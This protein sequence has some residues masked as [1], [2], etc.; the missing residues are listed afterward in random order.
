MG[1]FTRKSTT[2]RAEKLPAPNLDG[3]SLDSLMHQAETSMS[4]GDTKT[5]L[6]ALDQALILDPNNPKA[7]MKRAEVKREMR[8]E[9]G[10]IK[11]VS[12]AKLMLDKIDEGLKASDDGNAA[13][14]SGDYKN[15]VRNYNKAI[16]LLPSL[17][18]IY[19]WRGLSKQYMDDYT[20]ALEDFTLSISANAST[21]AD[22]FYA[23]G[24]I[25]F[26]KLGDSAGAMEDYNKA[27]ELK[28]DAPEVYRSRAKLVDDHAAVHDLTR[29]IELDPADP[30]TYIQRSLKMV[31]LQNYDAAVRDL[32]KVIEMQ[33]ANL[34]HVT[35]SEVFSMRANV[36]LFLYDLPDALHDADKAVECDPTRASA[37]LDRGMIKA[38]MKDRE[39][40]ISDL[41]NAIRLDASLADAYHERG[42]AKQA[43]GL[44]SE[45]NADIAKAKELGFV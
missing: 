27:L 10:A 12:M 7:Y 41:D 38:I 2:E 23:R 39:S 43:L 33:P 32:T 30:N 4:A 13:Y 17:T 40:A 29:A 34:D 9:R 8:D 15:A 42:L 14:S 28:P 19:Y 31:S 6:S 37:F 26:H 24:L 45:G 18:S 11:D 36:R 3:L 16:S 35:L 22:A 21:A 5:A 44:Q 25:K 20:G 1:W